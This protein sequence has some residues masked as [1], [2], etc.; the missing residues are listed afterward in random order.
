MLELARALPQL[1]KSCARYLADE[2]LSR[3]RVLSG[4]VR[5]LDLGFFRIGSEEYVDDNDT[6]GLATLEKRHARVS[7]RLVTFDYPAKG[8]QRRVQSVAEPSVVELIT[9]LKR[10]RGRGR[11]LLVYREAGRWVDVRSQDINSFIKGLTGANFTAKEFRTWSATVLAA[12][13]LAVSDGATSATARKRAVRRAVDEVG[14]YL[15]NT[16]AVARRSY[17][18]PRIVDRYMAGDTVASVF[19]RLGST[20]PLGEPSTQGAVE[21]AVLKLLDAQPKV[22]EQKAA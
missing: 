3:E 6:Y 12:V 2:G 1:R 18:D 20:V 9:E 10:R 14:H 15:G 11:S 8:G 13:A 19:A 21:K 22:A 17:V 7:D 16:A 5:L 4:A